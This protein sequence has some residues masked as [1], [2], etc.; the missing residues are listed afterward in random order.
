MNS[1]TFLG[2]PRVPFDELAPGSADVAIL[3]IPHG[4]PYAAPGWTAGCAA[5]PAAVRARSERLARFVDHHDFDLDGPMLVGSPP[6]RV[7][8]AG[9]VQ[10]D[11]ADGDPLGPSRG[12]DEFAVRPE[13]TESLGE[14]LGLDR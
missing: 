1:A 13:R 10:G 12:L 8:D 11:P 5:A 3:G 14:V 9:D 2:L 6:L 7:I 4:V